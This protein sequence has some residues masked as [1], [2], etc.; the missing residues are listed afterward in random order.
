MHFSSPWVQN[1][2]LRPWSPPEFLLG[3]GGGFGIRAFAH[4]HTLKPFRTTSAVRLRV[5]DRRLH[6]F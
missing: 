5:S 1:I 6:V 4:K 3:G 2:I